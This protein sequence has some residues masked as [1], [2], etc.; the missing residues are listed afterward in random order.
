M[1]QGVAV[2]LPVQCTGEAPALHREPS[3][4]SPALL[5]LLHTPR[6]KALWDS[7]LAVLKHT[8]MRTKAMAQPKLGQPPEVTWAGTAVT[9]SVTH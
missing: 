8:S 4:C 2:S 1:S 3:P 9:L 6:E 7:I 5:Q